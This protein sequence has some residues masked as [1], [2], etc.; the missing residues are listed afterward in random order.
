MRVCVCVHLWLLTDSRTPDPYVFAFHVY[1]L[2]FVLLLGSDLHTPCAVCGVECVG[3]TV[4]TRHTQSEHEYR[5]LQHTNGAHTHGKQIR[6][7][8]VCASL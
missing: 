8:L 5:A 2:L 4:H 7:G 6:M 1:V 3:V